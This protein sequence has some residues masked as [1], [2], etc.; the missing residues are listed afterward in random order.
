MGCGT[1]RRSC[2]RHRTRSCFRTS[3]PKI[4][5]SAPLAATRCR[6]PRTACGSQMKQLCSTTL[7]GKGKSATRWRSHCTRTTSGAG[8]R[9]CSLV[10]SVITTAR[11]AGCR[12]RRRRSVE[13]RRGQRRCGSFARCATAGRRR[14]GSSGSMCTSSLSTRPTTGSAARSAARGRPW[15]RTTRR[16]CRSRSSTTSTSTR[17]SCTFPLA[18]ARSRVQTS[19]ASPATTARLTRSPTQTCLHRC[20]RRPCRPRCWS[21]ISTR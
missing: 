19:R 6:R 9:R 17:S 18:L 14:P 3:S 10:Q 8:R 12:R 13:S 20:N 16:A 5:P 7:D 1:S 15:S 11:R 4:G 21:S 2:G